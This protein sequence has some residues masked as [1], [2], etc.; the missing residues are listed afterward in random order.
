MSTD[1]GMDKED[2]V[3]IYNGIWNN[4]SCSNTDGPKHYHTMKSVREIYHLYVLS[5]SIKMNL[6]A[7]Q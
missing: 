2:V 3:N 5:K 1:R 6:F 7:E 4:A